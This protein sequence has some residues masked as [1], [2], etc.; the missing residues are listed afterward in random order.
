MGL[1]TSER[2]AFTSEVSKVSSATVRPTTVTT[3]RT[4][5]AVNTDDRTLP[6]A[7]A[8]PGTAE[9]R[10]NFCCASISTEKHKSPFLSPYR[11]YLVMAASNDAALNTFVYKRS[12]RNILLVKERPQ[13]QYCTHTGAL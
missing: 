10:V 13:Y 7:A 8:T 6:P 12:P 1:N 9:I 11:N 2:R 5:A 3:E 4:A